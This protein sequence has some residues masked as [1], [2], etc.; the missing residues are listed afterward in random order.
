MSNDGVTKLFLNDLGWTSIQDG[1]GIPIDIFD[2]AYTNTFMNCRLFYGD[3]VSG[4][5]ARIICGNLLS[6]LTV[7]QTLKFAFAMT[8]PQ[9]LSTA[10][11]TQISIPIFV[12]SYDPYL[13][14]KINFNTIN[15]GGYINNANKTAIPNGFYS[16][17]NNEM[18]TPN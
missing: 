4:R 17:V 7:G 6:S 8:N 5:P 15:V 9:P 18:E 2:C 16:T 11:L 13:F 14:Q 10:I 12:Y 1:D 3:Y